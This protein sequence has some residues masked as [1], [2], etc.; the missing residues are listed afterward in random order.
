M[1]KEDWLSKFLTPKSL[2]LSKIETNF[3]TFYKPRILFLMLSDFWF[4]D[5]LS[6]TNCCIFFFLI[7][8]SWFTYS[9][10]LL[11]FLSLFYLPSPVLIGGVEIV[12]WLMGSS[13]RYFIFNL[14]SFVDSI[15]ANICI[16]FILFYFS[17]SAFDSFFYIRV[18]YRK[19]Q[20]AL[21]CK[22][23]NFY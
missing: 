22:G 19:P 14:E 8:A 12:S 9:R 20:E 18:E 1:S 15:T 7:W 5:S 3:C 2:C 23:V 11:I 17:F 4:E 16:S 13:C 6:R 21:F 10:L